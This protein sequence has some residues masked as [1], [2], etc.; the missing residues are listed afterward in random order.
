M[1]RKAELVGKIDQ[2]IRKKDKDGKESV[3]ITIYAQ[4]KDASSV[5]LGDVHVIIEGLQTELV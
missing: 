4:T 1:A 2:I 3:K 5:P